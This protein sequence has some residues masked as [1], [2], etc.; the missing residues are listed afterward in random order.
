MNTLLPPKLLFAFVLFSPLPLTAQDFEFEQSGLHGGGGTTVVAWDPFQSGAL[1]LG[2]DVSGVHRSEDYG[3]TWQAANAGLFA[4]SHLS[5]ASLLFHPTVPGLAFLACGRVGNGSGLFVSEDHGQSWRLLTDEIPFSGKKNKEI[6][7]DGLAPVDISPYYADGFP[8]SVG[9]LMALDLTPADPNSDLLYLASYHSG[10]FAGKI[11]FAPTL[12][13]E[14]HQVGGKPVPVFGPAALNSLFPYGTE[15]K[16]ASGDFLTNPVLSRGLAADFDRDRL[17]L[18]L[19]NNGLWEITVEHFDGNGLPVAPVSAS[20]IFSVPGIDTHVEEVVRSGDQLYFAAGPE[21]VWQRHDLG[22]TPSN[23]RIL[24]GSERI[25][26]VEPWWTSIDV[27][28]FLGLGTDFLLAGC[29]LPLTAETPVPGQEE[30]KHES[31]LFVRSSDLAGASSASAAWFDLTPDGPLDLV[32]GTGPP[33]ESWWRADSRY[34]KAGDATAQVS[35]GFGR[36]DFRATHLRWNPYAFGLQIGVAANQSLYGG[37][38]FLFEGGGTTSVGTQWKLKCNRLQLTVGRSLGLA[39]DGVVW[40]GVADWHLLSFDPDAEGNPFAAIRDWDR[41]QGGG[42]FASGFAF[43]NDH[44]YFSKIS[45]Q[46]EAGAVLRQD[47]Y[48]LWTVMLDQDLAGEPFF[49]MPGFESQWEPVAVAGRETAF[50]DFE[51]MVAIRGDQ[52]GGID[53]SGLWLAVDDGAG[54]TSFTWT[55]IP[56]SEVVLN[57]AD[58]DAV[59]S[60]CYQSLSDRFYVYNSKSGLFAVESDLSGVHFL[61]SWAASDGG[62]LACDA[63]TADRLWLSRNDLGGL[64]REVRLIDV[65]WSFAVPQI[66]SQVLVDQNDWVEGETL[67]LLGPLAATRSRR[68]LVTTMPALEGQSARLLEIKRKAS[69]SPPWEISFVDDGDQVYASF[70]IRP[71]AI[72]EFTPPGSSLQ[73]IGLAMEGTGFL[74]G[75]R[76]LQDEEPP[77]GGTGTGTE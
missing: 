34:L 1:L 70:A 20:Q 68:V 25:A 49:G 8:R 50:G 63:H 26:G 62:W 7:T 3:E 43:S 37:N 53:P 28:N 10:L 45:Q 41:P 32:S 5:V 51:L 65:D 48:G 22:G 12:Q 47:G 35:N 56:G 24:L 16:D 60:L 4:E 15:Y 31:V 77:G 46:N 59:I 6:F 52:E 76:M 69:S 55:K 61:A 72:L 18:G 33:L 29:N 21:G 36:F 54:A 14:F 39:P 27:L 44:L 58:G 42:A 66:A 57:H 64:L 38:L 17:Y 9:N 74:S 75:K 67:A 13:I 23:Q 2:G 19:L 11:S 73:W 40:V 71:N 30:E